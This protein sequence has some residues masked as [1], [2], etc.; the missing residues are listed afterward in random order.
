MA[1]RTKY[2]FASLWN[3]QKALLQNIYEENAILGIMLNIVY[4][5][6]RAGTTIDVTEFVIY[7]YGD[8]YEKH[9]RQVYWVHS[10]VCSLYFNKIDLQVEDEGTAYLHELNN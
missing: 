7:L 3:D 6:F 9:L 2:V 4:K 10:F 8:N 1:E 5:Y